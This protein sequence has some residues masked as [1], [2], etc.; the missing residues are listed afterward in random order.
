MGIATGTTPLAPAAVSRRRR[1]RF[2][3]P[4]AIAVLLA[5]SFLVVAANVVTDTVYVVVDPRIER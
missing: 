2:V 4:M 1:I 3:A 5:V